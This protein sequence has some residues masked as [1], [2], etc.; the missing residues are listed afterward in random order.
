MKKTCVNQFCFWLLLLGVA[1]STNLLA[2]TIY[3]DQDAAGLNTGT[4]WTNA[5][6]SL[7]SAL[8]AAVTNDQIWVAEGTYHPSTEYGGTGQ[9]YRA[10]QMKNGVAIYGGFD[11]T[12]GDD[13]FSER[14]WKANVTILSGVQA[15][16]DCYHVFYHPY[17][18]KLGPTA[19]LDGFTI[20][21]GYADDSSTPGGAGGGMYNDECS[22]TVKNCTFTGNYANMGGGAVYNVNFAEPYFE[23]CLF[24]DNA[25]GDGGGM[26]NFWGTD[27]ILVRCTFQDNIAENHAGGLMDYD[28]SSSFLRDCIFIHNVVTGATGKGGAIFCGYDSTPVVIN[29]LFYYNMAY[30]GAVINNLNSSSAELVN[31]T[32]ANNLAYNLG[33]CLYNYD[34]DPHLVNCIVFHNKP[35]Q[36]YNE[37]TGSTPVISYSD[38]QGGYSGS[39]NINVVPAFKH[40]PDFID[41]TTAAGS[42]TTIVVN[43]ALAYAYN[44]AIEIDNDGV[45]RV[46][47]GIK[48]NTITFSPALS[49]ASTAGML[50]I[51]W[52]TNGTLLS[53]KENYQLDSGGSPCIDVGY[54]SA[55][56]LPSMDLDGRPRILDGNDDGM[57][58][59]DMGAYEV[60]LNIIFVDRDAKGNNNG[61]SWSD[62]YLDLQDAFDDA[63]SGNEIWVAEGTYVPSNLVIAGNPRSAAFRLKNGVAV[64]GG[65]DPSLND[66]TWSRRDFINNETILSGDVGMMGI[67]GDNA[68]HVFYHPAT[69]ALNQTAI[70]DGFTITMAR[71]EPLS[72]PHNAGAGM[73]NNGCSPRIS[74]CV[75]RDNNADDY[76]GALMNDNAS[77][78]FENCTFQ[79][80]DTVCGGAV[81]N[82]GGAPEFS[83]CMFGAE[84]MGSRINEAV[85]GG[86]I[87]NKNTSASLTACQIR[88]NYAT[89]NGGGIYNEGGSPTITDCIVYNNMAFGTW[90]YGRGGGIFCQNSNAQITD[91]Q[92]RNNVATYYGGGVFLDTTSTGTLTGCTIDTCQ[93]RQGG[94]VFCDGA[95]STFESCV[96]SNNFTSDVGD[97]GGGI[98]CAADST[99]TL[100]NC[101]IEDNSAKSD[102]AGIYLD[103]A[104]PT[105]TDCLIQR[106][107]ATQKAGGMA[108]Y[109]YSAPIVT[110]C[111]FSQNTVVMSDYWGGGVSSSF[112][113]AGTYTG[114][115][116][117]G[118]TADFGA[119]FTT[120][121]FSSPTIV[122]CTFDNNAADVAGSGLFC[123]EN[124]SPLAVNCLFHHNATVGYAELSAV[125]FVNNGSDPDLINCTFVENTSGGW[126]GGICG[127]N[128]TATITSCIFW[129]NV[130]NQ[131][132]NPYP[133][134]PFS[135]NY[136]DVEGGWPGTRNINVDPLFVDAAAFNY[137][138]QE[139]SECIDNGKNATVPA[140]ATTDR[141]GLPRKVDG[142]C[143]G[144]IQVDIGAY[145]FSY[146]YFGSFDNDCD[147]DMV[148]FEILSSAWMSEPADAAWNRVCDISSPADDIID[149][150]DLEVF[151]ANWL[152]GR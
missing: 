38:V 44:H 12:V 129:D 148:D 144:S 136:C 15:G 16:A 56:K 2:A 95:S 73:Y 23:D 42:T 17:P 62:A 65:F 36:V 54:N 71:Q 101:T 124:S 141:D 121:Q 14:D 33:G 143:D 91:T 18:M 52:G 49:A 81:Y 4:S 145:E 6:T 123:N 77:G 55:S 115:T 100:N 128:G 139:T 130:P 96:I 126:A 7:Q 125:V 51:N 3:V 48:T 68:Y 120:E 47:S 134:T 98:Y 78:L 89:C 41:L 70:L 45:K 79:Y 111:T 152:T 76:G 102:G 103:N 88:L 75:F 11:P 110:G 24:I 8:A 46:I 72:Y 108:S 53:V 117:T 113:A 150:L 22:P 146:S 92:L 151:A 127:S 138:L 10:F 5:Y 119:G 59:V 132:T 28:D 131:I 94:G 60:N 31:C 1:L 19:Y 90:E 58:V 105:L 29:G 93:A 104:A 135:V 39:H 147:V 107:E 37:D 142:D 87:Y 13:A 27:A 67:P 30:N 40:R 43:S 74:N 83:G 32:I 66:A 64:Y 114:C 99:P 63:T 85:F 140:W 69:A 97:N 116:F 34:S 80:N 122:S 61:T 149:I 25:A 20:T 84:G 82:L 21:G 50:V 35:D 86:A 57:A 106:N 118:N 109:N 133:G 26:Y 137:R 9:V 112:Y